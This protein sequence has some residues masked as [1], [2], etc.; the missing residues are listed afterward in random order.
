M[1]R[2]M[3]QTETKKDKRVKASQRQKV[4]SDG[5]LA[6]RKEVRKQ[7]GR[8]DGNSSPLLRTV[9]ARYLIAGVC[10]SAAPAT[11]VALGG[12]IHFK[13]PKVILRCYEVREG[14]RG[15]SEEWRAG[16]GRRRCL[17]KVVQCPRND[18]VG[19]SERFMP[20]PTLEI[21]LSSGVRTTERR[22]RGYR[23]CSAAFPQR[24]ENMHSLF[25]TSMWLVNGEQK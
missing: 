10:A 23:G 24:C 7:K 8:K 20:N 17:E 1:N 19:R 3:R 9:R 4:T 13:R 16:T 25:C 22:G 11:A 6:R 21:V 14:G 12:V 5:V 2:G 15:R 18:S